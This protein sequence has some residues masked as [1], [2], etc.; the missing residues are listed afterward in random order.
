MMCWYYTRQNTNLLQNML[1]TTKYN[2]VNQVYS[3]K[4][5]QIQIFYKK[6]YYSN[7][8]KCLKKCY[9]FNEGF[10]GL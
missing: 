10:Y 6:I 9:G 5:F 4:E 8:S 2:F 7:S 1:N 3:V